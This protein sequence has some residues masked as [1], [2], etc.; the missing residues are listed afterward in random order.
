[1]TSTRHQPEF[2]N[3]SCRSLKKKSNVLI[4]LQQVILEFGI[5]HLFNI[6][7]RLDLI[8]WATLPMLLDL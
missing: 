3:N 4:S 7:E 2:Q 1:M 5:R 6:I 8:H